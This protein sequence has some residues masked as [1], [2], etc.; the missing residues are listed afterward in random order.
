MRNHHR[1]P[2]AAAWCLGALLLV[3]CAQAQGHL[4][5]GEDHQGPS[6]FAT[7]NLP[8][9]AIGH[10]PL[11]IL[12]WPTCD[13]TEDIRLE[14]YLVDT[15]ASLGERQHESRKMPGYEWTPVERR[16]TVWPSPGSKLRVEFRAKCQRSTNRS[17]IGHTRARGECHV[18]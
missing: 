16:L 5:A 11:T 2:H 9:E 6:G 17:G 15:G 14:V 7:C 4:K 13:T 3:G 1:L 18:P 8:H 12:V 10:P